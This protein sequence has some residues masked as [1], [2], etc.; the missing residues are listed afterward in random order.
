MKS[1]SYAALLTA[2]IS[3]GA[4]AS[5]LDTPEEV[6]VHGHKPDKSPTTT[7]S[8]TPD[9]LARTVNLITPEDTL[10]YL[11]D[12][13]IRQRHIG[14]TQAP[15]TTRTS[16]VG[17]SARS[18]IYV[19][20]IL[21][22]SLI[23]N[24]NTSASPKWGLIQPDAIDRVDVLYGPFSAAYAGNSLGSTIVFTTRM[25]D[26][27]EG[28]LDIQGAAQPFKLYGEAK[29]YGTGRVAGS[30][31]NRFGLLA[32]RLGVN[33]LDSQ[34]Q[35]L[36]YATA[37]VPATNGTAGTPVTG[38]FDDSN[39]TGAAIK[40]LGATSI[41]HQIQDNLSGR[42]TY[43]LSPTVTAAYTFGLF[44]NRDDAG[45]NSYLRDASGN[46]VY[47][48][49]I[50]IDNKTYTLASS[51]FSGGL[52]RLD[53]TQLAQGLSL[54]SHSDGRLD[55]ELVA[56]AFSYLHS[57]Q[58]SP[59]GALPAAF[60]GGA[61]TDAILD[62]TGWTTLDAKGVWRP[63]SVQVVSFGAH[64]DAFHLKSVTDLMSDWQGGS[65][66]ALKTAN[67]G[68]TRTQALW[69]QDAW[70]WSPSVTATVG[71]RWEDWHAD[72]GVTYSASPAL[73]VAQP[74]L[75]A[76]AFSPKAVIA[77]AP[78]T[79]TFKASLA[80][81][82]RFPT[83]SELYQAITTGPV[84]SVPNPNLRPERAVSAELSAERAWTGGNARLS[85]FSEDVANAL[86]S[87]SAPLVSGS[88]TLY[89]FVQNVD[90]TRANGVEF[91]GAQTLGK[92]QVS[93]WLTYV[94]ARI[95]K[96]TAFAA[97]VGK[98]LPQLPKWRGAMTVS[99]APSAKWDVALSGRYSDRAFG[100]IDNSDPRADTFQGFSGYFVADLHVR[101]KVNPHVTADVGVD[102]LNDRKYFI[103][104]PF[105]QRTF[106]ADLKYS[107]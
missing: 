55:Y 11:P 98:Q 20:G 93:G 36:A 3:C 18:L 99:Y 47:V 73:N 60:S 27:L 22:S 58:V 96:D 95:V 68:R 25:P 13:L 29:T 84:L 50:N 103:Y 67:L 9:D 4:H 28:S 45:V 24:N 26:A 77:W 23:G 91:V 17:A 30:I 44:H 59:S 39:R 1:I 80:E 54:A 43:D 34:A 87:Q 82:Y 35:P 105:P 76:Q 14:D 81:A 61:G 66:G 6:I 74:A 102:N 53:E 106:I 2:L 5:D 78:N 69:V 48:G 101:Y 49:S 64:A 107:L 51:A 104:H 92:W 79:W 65:D 88:T 19:D 94:D 100:T 12:V 32:V 38:A 85:L 72:R 31:G 52:Y 33:H 56:T 57:H 40:V 15:V 62:G 63:D 70:K 86:L 10:R 42:V 89:S 90:R 16:G 7:A 46:V 97:A 37:T 21:L 41:E 71:G 75:K 8:V 83:V